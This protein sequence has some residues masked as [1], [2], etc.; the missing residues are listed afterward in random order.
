[1]RQSATWSGLHAAGISH[2]RQGLA[3]AIHTHFYLALHAFLSVRARFRQLQRSRTSQRRGDLG[4]LRLRQLG[5]ALRPPRLRL[6]PLSA[7]LGLLGASG[8]HCWS[9]R[10]TNAPAS[11]RTTSALRSAIR[12]D[13]IRLAAISPASSS[14]T[15][16][17][18]LCSSPSIRPSTTTRP[19]SGNPRGHASGAG[20]AVVVV[21][22]SSWCLLVLREGLIK[23]L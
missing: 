16:W 6:V 5:T 19:A 2:W 18:A 1:M 12:D 17:A 11:T 14:S 3:R 21:P 10:G 22:D 15:A 23:A 4:E 7:L 20:G 9:M 13:L 8:G